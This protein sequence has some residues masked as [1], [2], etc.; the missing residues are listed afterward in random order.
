MVKST[1]RPT[2]ELADYIVGK[3]ADEVS[4]QID[5]HIETCLDCQASLLTISTAN[6]A[7]L[8]ILR[9]SSNDNEFQSELACRQG[10]ELIERLVLSIADDNQ[11][12][13]DDDY[14]PANSL[15]AA[16]RQ[17]DLEQ[18]SAKIIELKLVSETACRRIRDSL[19]VAHGH[20]SRAF[21]DLLVA[22]NLLTEY[23][24]S[25]VLQGNG[26]TSNATVSRNT[27]TTNALV[28]TL[29]SDDASEATVPATVTILAGQTS[30]TFTVDSVDDAIVDGTQPVT[31]TASAATFADGTDD[32][33]VTDDD[34]PTLALTIDLATMPENGGTSNATVSRNT[35]TTAD[36]VVTLAS[37]DT[38]EATVPVSVTIL[39]GQTSATFTVTAVDDG[40]SDGDQLVGIIATTAG[41]LS[42]SQP[43]TVIDIG[44]ANQDPTSPNDVNNA[45]NNVGEGAAIG[46]SVGITANSIDPDGNTVSYSLSDDAGGR[47]QIDSQSGVVSVAVGSLLSTRSQINCC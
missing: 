36:L 40:I 18:F 41:F 13:N 15:L 46:T 8:S 7:I 4:E 44:G 39:A 27:D 38:S 29:A 45:P 42:S 1:C 10:V 12:S 25:Q 6:D 2:D 14:G 20:D 34:V 26:G 47:F 43:I 5:E 37:N 9:S 23:Q 28:V 11:K 31:I 33:N 19:P 24:A 3:L 17:I 16:P 21:A 22:S 30:A 32:I 35:D